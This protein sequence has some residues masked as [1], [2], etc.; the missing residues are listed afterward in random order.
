MTQADGRSAVTTD[1]LNISR[2]LWLFDQWNTDFPTMC[3][4]FREVFADDC[5][6]ENAGMSAVRGYDEAFEKILAPSNAD[7]FYMDAIRVD[8][9]NIMATGNTVF[10]ERVDHMLRADGSQ[11]I[12]I[13]IA[14]VTVFD[15]AGQIRHWRDY[16]DPAPLFALANGTGNNPAD[17]SSGTAYE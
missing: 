6:W 11:I 16:C 10:H 13:A 8:T 1:K 17:K 5:V 2:I 3:A 14:G 9:L 15:D 12:S 4:A 7:P